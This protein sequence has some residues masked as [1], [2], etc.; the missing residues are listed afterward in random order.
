[1]SSVSKV[2]SL[3]SKPTETKP[4]ETKPNDYAI[5]QKAIDDSIYSALDGKISPNSMTII[6]E[7]ETA[8]IVPWQIKWSHADTKMRSIVIAAAQEFSNSGAQRLQM[9]DFKQRD[10]LDAINGWI[11]SHRK[12]LY[13]N[14]LNR[15]GSNNERRVLPLTKESATSN[16]DWEAAIEAKL[17]FAAFPNLNPKE[18]IK[19][20]CH[21]TA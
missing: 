14:Y 3:T 4:T 11:E 7:A 10:L 18:P 19:G 16:I 1:M 5:I 20:A 13:V 21:S 9:S 12:P 6:K 15:R 2:T 8:D 17:L